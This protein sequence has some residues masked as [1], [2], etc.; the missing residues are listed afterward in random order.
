MTLYL[1]KTGIINVQFSLLGL[2]QQL[3]RCHRAY[4][5]SDVTPAIISCDFV[6]HLYRAIKS[7]HTT[8]HVT[9]AM[10]SRTSMASRDSDDHILATSYTSRQA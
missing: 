1:Y 3:M 4:N 7:L 6:A 5:R 10:K 9:T 2:K 8:V